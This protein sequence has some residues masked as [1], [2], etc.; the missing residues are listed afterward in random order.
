MRILVSHSNMRKY[1]AI[2]RRDSKNEWLQLR[3]DMRHGYAEMG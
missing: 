2:R 1:R 3:S